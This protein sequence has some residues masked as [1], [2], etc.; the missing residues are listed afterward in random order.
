MTFGG[1]ARVPLT[2]P[3]PPPVRNRGDVSDQAFH[4]ATIIVMTDGDHV[5][6]FF[7]RSSVMPNTPQRAQ[8]DA[9]VE[10]MVFSHEAAD[11]PVAQAA[12]GEQAHDVE[13][14]TRTAASNGVPVR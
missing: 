11:E 5:F 6:L 8:P 9:A 4:L 12:T 10:P 2:I 14:S 7:R 1:Q 13:F 3:D